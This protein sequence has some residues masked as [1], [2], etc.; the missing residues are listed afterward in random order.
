[1]I[2]CSTKQYGVI[3][4]KDHVKGTNGARAQ[5]IPGYTEYDTLDTLDTLST[6]CY[7]VHFQTNVQ[8]TWTDT[9]I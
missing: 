5:R 6:V 1:M 8:G 4:T 7:T 9:Y 2:Y 3:S